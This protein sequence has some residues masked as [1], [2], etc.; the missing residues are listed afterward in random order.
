MD[1]SP[2]VFR[3]A[4]EPWEFE[5]IHRLNY[6]T[7]VEEIPQHHANAEKLL[8]DRFN[9]QNTYLI[10]LQD[11]QLAGMVAVRGERPFSLDQKLPDLD[12]YLPPGR[13]VC[14]VR[15]LSVLPKFRGSRVFHGLLELLLDYCLARGY[16]LAVISGTVRQLKLYRHLGFV[17][18]GP[19]VGTGEA[20]YQPMSITREALE[21][22]LPLLFT[23]DGK[24]TEELVNLLPGPVGIS[25]PVRRALE[26]EP[27]S[28]RSPRFI[29]DFQ[30]TRRRLCALTGAR[31][32]EILAGTGTLANDAVACQLAQLQRPGL[33][34]SNGEFGERLVDQAR[35]LGLQFEHLA[36]PWG[37]ALD[38][39]AVGRR[40]AARKGPAWLWTVH[41]E[42]S[43]GVLNDV[44]GLAQLCRRRKVHLCLDCISSLGAA[45]VDL[46]GVALATAVSGKGLG[47]FPGLA[48]VFTASPF[49][50]AGAAIPRYL[51]LA[52]YAQSA[53]IPFTHPSNL[54][55]AL[56]EALRRLGD[57]S[58]RF[59]GL[60]QLSEH[61]RDEL[62]ELGF[63]LVGEEARLSPAVVTIALP[64]E[65]PSVL[66]GDRMAETGYL[67]S[68][69]SGYLKAR[70]W[71][72]VCL[73]GEY[74]EEKVALLPEYL[75][76][77]CGKR[78][79]EL[80]TVAA[81]PL[82]RSA[83]TDQGVRPT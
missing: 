51:D 4:S 53:G 59:A 47:A 9:A 13:K 10:C 18:F 38:L 36:F 19:L 83:A 73:M 22:A 64:E 81:M 7:F 82:A 45:P 12:S 60:R 74:P 54:H 62:R 2:L 8:V 61:L 24:E 28:H 11:R 56:L 44:A 76:R 42:T 63:A 35:R 26:G 55:Y 75:R 46:S 78:T 16:D 66:I 34:L 52:L 15:L 1:S 48:M 33:I 25:R 6:R 50:Q 69:Q 27:I 30:E 32:V 20:L 70:N 79:E 21:Q 37:S 67:L 71:L 40:L 72:Q 77:V 31:A 3:V 80:P 41:C 17:P 29:R 65:L 58:E 14:E 68:Y 49:P 23:A 39:E 43:S 57:G 5:Q